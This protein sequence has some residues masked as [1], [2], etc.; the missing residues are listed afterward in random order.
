MRNP[1]RLRRI[2]AVASSLAVAFALAGPRARADVTVSEKTVFDGVGEGGWGA[3][4][5]E[6]VTIVSG[7]KLRQE[8]TSKP[9]GKFMRRFAGKGGLRS[10]TITRLDRKLTYM[11][12]YGSESYQEVPLASF[13]E[14]QETMMEAMA[15]QAPPEEPAEEPET[16]ITCSPV[17]V[18]VARPGQ[19]E[20]IGGFEAERVEVKGEQSCENAQ[21]KQ[22]CRMVYTL[23]Y[24]VT[25]RTSVFTE[26]QEFY[27]RQAQAMGM[28]MDGRQMQAVARAAGALAS[29]KTEGFETVLKE[30][31]KLE[32]Y[33]V[34]T[35]I[36]IEKGGDC[37][38]MEAAG[39][40][41]AMREMKRS[42]KGLFGK[43]EKSEEPSTPAPGLTKVFGMST[44]ILSVATSSAPADA[45]EPPAGFK[46]RES[47]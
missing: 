6:S 13:K 33:P 41:N 45:F 9:T 25:P 42:F 11:I 18:G 3:S 34:R 20:T 21:T 40:T 16:Q 38:E 12:D 29:G 7:D 1:K 4:E 47:N 19:K 31:G 26:L 2:V 5:G 28:E 35:R 27:R 39:D 10:A 37:G 8:S 32:G 44:E 30:L 36:S 46:R 43:K 23:E 17:E 14:I 22:T 24:W 15:G